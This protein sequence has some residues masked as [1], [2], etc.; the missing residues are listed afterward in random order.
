MPRGVVATRARPSSRTRYLGTFFL[1]GGMLHHY[2]IQDKDRIFTN[3]YGRHDPFI[4][5]ATARGDWCAP[6]HNF[7]RL[8]HVA[9]PPAH[10]RGLACGFHAACCQA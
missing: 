10:E 5:G 3:I 9:L 1:I 7:M 6:R 2:G 4:K 8:R